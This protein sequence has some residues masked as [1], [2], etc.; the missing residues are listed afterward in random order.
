MAQLP[1]FTA[2][3]NQ[4]REF[5]ESAQVS[6]VGRRSLE[7]PL[8]LQQMLISAEDHRFFR[9]QGFDVRAIFRAIFRTLTGRTE[10][11]STIA[12][13]LARISTGRFERTI[14]RKIREIR[15][16]VWITKQFHRQYIPA[17]YLAEAYYGWRMNGLS[18][19]YERLNLAPD[20]L[21]LREAAELV[22]RLKYPEAKAAPSRRLQQIS[23]RADHILTLHA[24]HWA[25]EDYES[26]R[27]F[28]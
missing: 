20:S 21:T 15:I 25:T 13:Q 18:Q 9:H 5:L 17:L 7:V 8:V 3:L 16:S 28:E 19:A 2:D 24:R 22:A 4:V 12:Q 6:V 23:M 10:G 14:P 1:P 11:G 27:L 26:G